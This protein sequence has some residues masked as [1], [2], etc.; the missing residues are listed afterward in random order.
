MFTPSLQTPIY[1]IQYITYTRK[2]TRI[3]IIVIDSSA[4][5]AGVMSSLHGIE[6]AKVW[7]CPLPPQKKKFR[8]LYHDEQHPPQES[9][10]FSTPV[11]IQFVECDRSEKKTNTLMRLDYDTPKVTG[12]LWWSV[13]R[14][15]PGERHTW[16]RVVVIPTCTTKAPVGLTPGLN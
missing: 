7:F 3:S 16:G 5:T 8:Y 2:K 12:G 14:G 15:G 9:T 4:E 11:D 1:S 13:C 10:F 6:G